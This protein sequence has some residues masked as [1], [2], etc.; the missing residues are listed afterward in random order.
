MAGWKAN[1]HHGTFCLTCRIHTH[2]ALALSNPFLVWH[3]AA[4]IGSLFCIILHHKWLFFKLSFFLFLLTTRNP[5]I[6]G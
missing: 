5:E 3:F 2:A 6:N 1:M 4:G